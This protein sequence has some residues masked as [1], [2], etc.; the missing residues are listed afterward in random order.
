MG[1]TAPQVLVISTAVDEATDAVV[2][3]LHARGATVHRFNTEE[4]PF[5]AG[6][7]MSW[8][9]GEPSAWLRLPEAEVPL[10]A[11]TSCWYRRVRVPL[12]PAAMEAGPYEFALRESRSAVLGL[13][14]SQQ[15]PLMNN[16]TYTWAAEV[17]PWQL[18]AAVRCGLPIPATVITNDPTKVRAAFSSWAGQMIA[19]PV[20]SGYLE[21]GGVGRAIFTSAVRAADLA[22]DDALACAPAIYQRLVP[23][24]CDVRVTVVGR[25][26]FAAEILS[27]TDPAACIDWR[28]TSDAHLPHQPATLP[29]RLEAVLLELCDLLG[30]QFAAI[31]LVRTVEDDYVF[32]EV[33]PGGQWLWIEDILGY[34]ITGSVADWLLAPPRRAAQT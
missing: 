26:V 8:A 15:M 17:K 1:S 18:T 25:R 23:K 5:H 31:D 19:K 11:L 29:V 12:R 34:P 7:T 14:L 9:A 16:P 27:Q 28:R 3:A 2:G 32:L 20:R 4:F 21:E 22:D 30:L 10:S 6:L 24:R 13:A 33:N